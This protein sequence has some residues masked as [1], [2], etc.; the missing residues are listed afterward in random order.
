MAEATANNNVKKRI[1]FT[2]DK[3]TFNAAQ[4]II[5]KAGLSSSTLISM[6]YSEIA[7]TGKIPVNLQASDDDLAK[8]KII[9]AS[10]DLPTVKLNNAKAISDFLND[11]G[12]Y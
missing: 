5:K 3:G 9:K 1:S 6:I 10:Y 4:Y 7:N 12:G 2:M 11:D 8:A